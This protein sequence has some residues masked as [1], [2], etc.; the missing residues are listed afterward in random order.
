MN[1]NEQPI[2]EPATPDGRFGSGGGSQP[3]SGPSLGEVPSDVGIPP[4]APP[5]WMAAPGQWP[6]TPLPPQATRGRQFPRLLSSRMA[7]WV[8]AALL[9]CAVVGLSIV[10]ATT[11]SATTARSPAN[12][13]PAG[14][15]VPGGGPFAGRFGAGLGGA[16]GTV[17]SVAASSFT[18]TT[19]AGQ[20]MT[21]DELSSTTYRN[22]ASSASASAVTSGARVLVFGSTSG[23]TIKATQV[24][25]LPTG[26]GGFGFP[27]FSAS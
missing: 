13:V 19:R 16:S 3:T 5:W 15:L 22:G 11:P 25:V 27:G 18:M 7:G 17:D 6:S 26:A 8:V 12:R 23:S 20:K 24:I 1:E 21:A 4:P 10:V 2:S 14:G 9:A